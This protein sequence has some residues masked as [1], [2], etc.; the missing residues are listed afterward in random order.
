MTDAQLMQTK[1]LLQVLNNAIGLVADAALHAQVRIKS[2]VD[3]TIADYNLLR[4][5]AERERW[6]TGVA[7]KF[8]GSPR[9]QITDEGRAALAQM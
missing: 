4:D 6:I 2:G 8:T 9:W 3:L 7:S 1:F 5:H